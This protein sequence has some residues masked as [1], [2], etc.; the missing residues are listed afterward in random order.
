MPT[1]CNTYTIHAVVQ[2]LHKSTERSPKANH[3]LRTTAPARHPKPQKQ[4]P[5]RQPQPRKAELP[6]ASRSPP[7]LRSTATSSPSLLNISLFP[8]APSN[9]LVNSRVH[10]IPL[11]PHTTHTTQPLA[12]TTP[13]HCPPASSLT[14]LSTP[15][16]PAT[17][18]PQT[19]VFHQ[20][21]PLHAPDALPR[22]YLAR[23]RRAARPVLRAKVSRPAVED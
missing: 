2:T 14:E 20:N 6:S 10:T 13:R 18:Q 3:T 8:H 22:P 17:T 15:T 19:N 12:I 7:V 21:A 1:H 4:L 16:R 5:H 9:A 23:R 11:L